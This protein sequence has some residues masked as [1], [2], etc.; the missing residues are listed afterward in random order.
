[1]HRGR[2]LRLALCAAL[3]SGCAVQRAGLGVGPVEDNDLGLPPVDLG[4]GDSAADPDLGGTE[5]DLGTPELDSGSLCDPSLCA[6]RFCAGDDCGYARSCNELKSAPGGPT[7]DGVY[8]LDGD[9]P[10]FLPAADAYCDMTNDVGGW[11]LVMKVD[12]GRTTFAYEAAYWTNDIEYP[13]SPLYDAVEA[14]LRT[15][16]TVAF[17]QMRIVF[18]TRTETHAV[19]LDIG[20]ISC[21]ALFNAGT[22]NTSVSRGTW[23]GLVPGSALQDN[24]NAEGINIAPGGSFDARTRIGIVANEQPNCSSPNSRIGIGGGDPPAAGNIARWN[25]IGGDRN[26]SSFAYV[27][28]R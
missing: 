28:V 16:R 9:G 27:F 24:C 17:T 14:K 18:V 20:A 23:L 2:F 6:G 4:E 13:M 15:F 8:T 22:F 25:G 7:T 12:G 1:M 3:A 21:V 5:L 19:V 10:D 26:I 11:T